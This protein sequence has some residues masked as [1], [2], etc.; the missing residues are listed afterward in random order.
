MIRSRIRA[1]IIIIHLSIWLGVPYKPDSIAYISWSN[2]ARVYFVFTTLLR[3]EVEARKRLTSLRVHSRLGYISD[4]TNGIKSSGKRV[5]TS[6]KHQI[7]ANYNCR[8][9]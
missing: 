4:F 9:L 1:R 6:V 2:V 5:N 7:S 8:K 3:F